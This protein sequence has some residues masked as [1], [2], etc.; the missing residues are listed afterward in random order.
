MIDNIV[1]TVTG[2]KAKVWRLNIKPDY[3]TGADHY[4]GH[5]GNMAIHETLNGVTINGSIAKYMHGENETPLTREQVAEGLYKLE[6]ETGLNL[7]QAILRRVEI[8]TSIILQNPV[9]EY[10]RNFD[11]L[12]R[13]KR[14]KIDNTAGLESVTYH[15]KTGAVA[16]C[17]YDKNKELAD[18]G[19]HIPVLFQDCN[20]ARLEYR[21][22]NRTGIKSLLGNGHDLTPWNITDKETYRTLAGQFF[23]FYNSIPKTGRR[24]FIDGGR[25]LKPSGFSEV[26]AEAYKQG[27]PEQYR[28]LLQQAIDRGI[29][30]SKSTERIREKG[31]KNAR[32]YT[33]SDTNG[34]ITELDE[35]VQQWASYGA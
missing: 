20:I 12:P 33:F 10:L 26:L 15:T 27:H 14:I 24:I 6:K 2:P 34:L 3:Q 30:S 29:V 18:G 16:F 1:F 13:Y 7:K 11:P 23:D 8:G 5:I 9:A 35:K 4:T 28:A 19:E 21:I 31:R 32:N 25:E 17:I 22:L